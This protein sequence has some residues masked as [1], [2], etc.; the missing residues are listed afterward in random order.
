[1]AAVSASGAGITYRWLNAEENLLNSDGVPVRTFFTEGTYYFEV[2]DT[3]RNCAAR[4]EIF[5]DG[6]YAP[7]L[8]DAGPP[9]TLYC[10]PASTRL[11]GSNSFGHRDLAY[12]WYSPEG[13]EI[14]D[15][16]LIRPLVNAP[17]YYYLEIQDLSN[18][19]IGLDSVLVRDGRREVQFSL[20][21][22]FFLAC[23]PYQ[24][25]LGTDLGTDQGYAFEWYYEDS[26]LLATGA[27]AIARRPGEYRVIVTEE[28]S[29]CES[30]G[31]THVREGE[32][33]P[34]Q[35]ELEVDAPTCDEQADGRVTIRNIRGGTGPYL[36][37]FAERGFV[38][39]AAYDRLPAGTYPLVVRD[40]LGCEHRSQI[41]LDNQYELRLDIGGRLEIQL[42]EEV[43]LEAGINRPLD[44]LVRLDWKSG[45]EVQCVFC[46]DIP[47]QPLRNQHWVAEA[48]DVNGCRA[49]DEVRIVVKRPY[50]VHLPSAFSPNQDGNNDELSIYIGPDLVRIN[51]FR[52]FDRWGNLVHALPGTDISGPA[53]LSL[54]DGRSS[55]REYPMAVYV[56]Q[57]EAEF[58][59]GTIR[60][61]AGDVLLSR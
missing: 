4:Q 22:T 40:A 27:E 3:S 20:A 43:L 47:L 29:G 52:I 35:Y 57:L 34:G 55:S 26:T 8:V 30:E 60:Q 41:V 32:E 18:G 51:F 13:H 5:L 38:P 21:D 6:D 39:D 59:D 44:S 23:N 28:A 49:R 16:A 25:S 48:V 14:E 10:T 19:C 54:W 12:R 24:V 9:A 37:D 42:G 2:A 17:G 45:G 15:P 61:F 33:I 56:Y 46:P 7:P 53:Q 36:I 1:M 58:I 11:D 50:E 31:G